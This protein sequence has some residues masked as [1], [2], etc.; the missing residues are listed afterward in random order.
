MAH[1]PGLASLLTTP[2]AVLSGTQYVCR[3]NTA[4]GDVF[5]TLQAE[6]L[7]SSR[8]RMCARTDADWQVEIRMLHQQTALHDGC[9]IASVLRCF[10]SIDFAG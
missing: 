4:R 7:R 8:R 3:I 5:F 1:G 6:Q 9:F 2:A 10:P